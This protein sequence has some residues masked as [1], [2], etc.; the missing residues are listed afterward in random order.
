M[1]NKTPCGELRSALATLVSSLDLSAKL[2]FPGNASAAQ[3]GSEK[4][5][6]KSMG[7]EPLVPLST[8]SQQAPKMQA[9]GASVSLSDKI[10]RK[11]EAPRVG[12]NTSTKTPLLVLTGEYQNGKSTFL[13]CLLGGKYAV[14]GDGRVTT[15]YNARYRFGDCTMV[16]G[17]SA[18]GENETT[19]WQ[20]FSTGDT[21]GEFKKDSTLEIYAN[22]PILEHMDLLDSP[23]C[24]ANEADDS[25]AENAL[26][27]ADFV[28]FVVRKTLNQKEITFI[29]QLTEAGKHYSIFLNCMNDVSPVSEKA[30]ALCQD[31]HSKLRNE[32]LLKNYVELSTEFPVYP[33]NLLWAQCALGY[34]EP[35]EQ[36]KK[37]RKIK[38][39]LDCEDKNISP[40]ALLNA[41]NFLQVRIMLKNVVNTF[42][43]YTPA[44]NLQLFDSVYDNL[45]S[46]LKQILQEK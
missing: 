45:V 9:E 16:R 42:F 35:E 7:Q 32:N 3:T 28:I 13:N 20:F 19:P 27:M 22:S 44:D 30:S 17:I 12:S 24:G 5:E 38:V 39:Y 15:K 10:I 2:A 23:G 21:L 18:Q 36:K 41:S 11:L 29:N 26:Q 46:E 1:P 6:E 8:N 33:I 40:I 37:L 25:V 34:L 14:E 43:N 4:K 31:I